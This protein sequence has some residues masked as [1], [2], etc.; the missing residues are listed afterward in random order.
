MKLSR[1]AALLLL[2]LICIPSVLAQTGGQESP[3]GSGTPTVPPPEQA[4]KLDTPVTVHLVGTTPVTLSYKSG[5]NETVSITAR[6]LEAQDVLDPMLNILDLNGATLASNDD[7]RTNRTDLA[8]RDSLIANLTLDAPGRYIIEVSAVDDTMQGDVEVLV[9]SGSATVSTSANQTIDQTIAD[10]GSYDANFQGNAGDVVT[11]T[12][13]ATDGRFDPYT[14][15]LDSS[16][17]LLASN[18]DHDSNDPN[19]GAYD[20]QIAN[21]TLPSTGT[22]TVEVTAS[23][24]VGGAFELTISSGGGSAPQPTSS[25]NLTPTVVHGTVQP[26][27]VYTYNF[28]GN[29][30]D[31]YTITVQA[32]S[33]NFD[34]RVTVYLNNQYVAD[35]DDYGTTDPNLQSTDA[36]IYDL[37]LTDSGSYEIDVRGYQDSSGDFTMTLDPIATNAPTT[38]PVEDVELGSVD[39]GNTYSY[40]FTAQAGDWVTIT[41]RGLSQGFDPYIS[42]LDANGNVL[43]DNDDNGSG[44]GALAFLD[45]QI[46]N[47]H[48]TES[49][50]YTVEV[51]GYDAGGSFGL[52]IG[53]LR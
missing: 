31:V 14:T 24:R 30:G 28:D 11:I 25:P 17:T 8:P 36:R 23:D 53:T 22:Y 34:P 38:P 51:S 50:T 33:S 16:G 27:A 37:I 42:L 43:I 46:P 5:G 44:Y 10:N 12:V 26:N 49:G 18:D 15:L 19:L 52:T 13:R 29:A 35:N 20:S 32:D 7:H 21:F 41:A 47:Y 4:I 6:S 3:G 39:T 9:S 1:T 40:N 45:A 2:L 48:I